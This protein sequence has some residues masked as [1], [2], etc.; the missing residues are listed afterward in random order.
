MTIELRKRDLFR[1]GKAIGYLLGNDV[2]LQRNISEA[3][4]HLVRELVRAKH[5]VDVRSFVRPGQ[6]NTQAK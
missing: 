5:G 6:F 1:Y 4:E 2:F 3:D